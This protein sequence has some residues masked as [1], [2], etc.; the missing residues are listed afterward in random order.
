MIG[1]G[2]PSH[3]RTSRRLPGRPASAGAPSL[4]ATAAI[5]SARSPSASRSTRKKF[6]S[7]GRKANCCVRS[8]RFK[9]KNGGFWGAEFCTEVVR[10]TR[11][12]LVAFCF[13]GTRSIQAELRAQNDLHSTDNSLPPSRALGSNFPCS[14]ATMRE[15]ESLF[16][17]GWTLSGPHNRCSTPR[18][19]RAFGPWVI[20]LS[21]E[22]NTGEP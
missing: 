13:G 9:H 21:P 6:A 1:L 17:Q 16:S 19:C 8:S 20:R 15:R 11:F 3:R 2:R 10:P 5:T 12:E 22:W 18:G 14:R 4:A 7:W